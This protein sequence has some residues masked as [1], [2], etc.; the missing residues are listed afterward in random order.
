MQ[1]LVP[2]QQLQDTMLLQ[3]LGPTAHMVTTSGN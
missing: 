2:H 3:L 1:Q